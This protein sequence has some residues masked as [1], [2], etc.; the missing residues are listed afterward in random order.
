MAA[1]AAF[2]ERASELTLDPPRRARRALAAARAKHLAGAPDAALEL[3]LTAE[4]GPL[5][6]LEL[7]RVDLLRAQVAYAQ[8]VAA[9]LRRCCSGPPDALSLL[10]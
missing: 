9:T 2:L 6:E 1:E 8:T 4:A 3:L 7:A 10:T 5:D